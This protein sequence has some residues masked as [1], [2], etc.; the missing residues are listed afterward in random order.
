MF[1]TTHP[2]EWPDHVDCVFCILSKPAEWELLLLWQG[3]RLL[4]GLTEEIW[5]LKYKGMSCGGGQ[6]EMLLRTRI[7]PT[8]DRQTWREELRRPRRQFACHYAFRHHVTEQQ[9]PTYTNCGP[10][11]ISS[12]LRASPCGPFPV[13]QIFWTTPIFGT[14]CEN[15]GGI[16]L[17]RLTMVIMCV[18]MCVFYGFFAS[19]QGPH[20]C[21]P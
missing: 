19:A 2:T 16:I 12:L 8:P 4:P 13:M 7:T 10:C 15:V 3:Q 17:L 1:S 20:S 6:A 14:F 5:P 9:A 18:C 21:T 11:S